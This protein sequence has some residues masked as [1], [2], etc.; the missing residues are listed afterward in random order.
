MA[1][2]HDGA[3]LGGRQLRDRLVDEAGTRLVEL[4]RR[5]VREQQ[6]RPVRERGAERDPLL[7]AA[8]EL[9]GA[10]AELLAQPDPA[11]Q[12]LGAGSPV[13][14]L[15]AEAEPDQLARGQLGR[16]RLLVVLVEIAHDLGAVARAAGAAER[17]EVLAEDADRP[18]RGKVEAGEDPQERRLARP[19]RAE[20]GQDL[21]LGD[22]QGQA[23]ERGG[24][25]LG[26]RV[27]AEE[28]LG[29]DRDGHAAP[30]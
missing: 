22:A 13:A 7:L 28:V 11:Q 6:P 16:E 21:A 9:R 20:H 25:A 15:G 14:P 5:L 2:D 1:D 8:G 19:A 29:L 27:D 17:A 24:V 10:G 4:A 26:R 3:A 18:G 30:P 12:L 23:L